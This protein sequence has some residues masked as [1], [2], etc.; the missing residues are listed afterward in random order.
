MSKFHKHHRCCPLLWRHQTVAAEPIFGR[1]F[2]HRAKRVSLQ[3]N[4]TNQGVVVK[5]DPTVEGSGGSYC[6]DDEGTP[7][8]KN[9][10]IEDGVLVRF[11]TDRETAAKQ[12]LRLR[13]NG[14]R[15]SY[16]VPPL[17]RMSNTY[18]CGGDRDPAA[19]ISSME[20][21]ILVK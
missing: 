19:I 3:E 4:D 14:R 16:R 1:T 10:L 2:S 7:A 9:L 18:I 6:F 5:D 17:S 8:V 12:K 15:G 20:S 13:G 21:G 11:L